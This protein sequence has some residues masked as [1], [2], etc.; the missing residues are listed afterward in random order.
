MSRG[1]AAP[2]ERLRRSLGARLQRRLFTWFA[3]TMLATAAFSVAVTWVVLRLAGPE[4]G[5]GSRR[6]QERVASNLARVWA[7]VPARTAEFEALAREF[8][9]PVRLRDPQGRALLSTGG[10]CR[11]PHWHSASVGDPSRPLATLDT[12]PKPGPPPHLLITAG[13][14][15]VTLWG[16]AG[17][18]ARRLSRPLEEVARIAEEIN[19]GNLQ[20]AAQAPASGAPAGDEVA[21]VGEVLRQMAQRIDKQLRD[22]RELLAAVSHELRTPLGHLRLMLDNWREAAQPD[23]RLLDQAERE[24]QDLD[25]LVG[26]LLANARLEFRE[27]RL[28]RLDAVGLAIEALERAGLDPTVLDVQGEK[29]NVLADP[30]LLQRAVA[31]LLDNARKHGG[32][33]EALRLSEEA[34]A[35]R[36]EVQDDG[37]GFGVGEAEQAFL[38]FTGAG[39]RAESLG[40]G[41]HLVER[42]AQAHGGRAFARNAEGGGAIVGIELPLAPADQPS[43]A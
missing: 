5:P 2:I 3:A 40:L 35:V 24:L 15:L 22:Q 20:A 25:S 10:E 12:C 28:V 17:L 13:L 30:A 9:G 27:L 14:M 6:I 23:P 39:H 19:G 21:V 34:A 1:G 37:P 38:P 11:R 32:G 18:L 7:D 36:L 31:N 29:L 4:F 43:E 16:A 26:Q 8:D 41:L 33:A 42:I